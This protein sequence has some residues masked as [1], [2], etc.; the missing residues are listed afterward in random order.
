M[1]SVKLTLFLC[2][3]DGLALRSLDL[4]ISKMHIIFY[5]FLD[6]ISL[7]FRQGSL[8][9]ATILEHQRQTNSVKWKLALNMRLQVQQNF[10]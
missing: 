2:L 10:P 1:I 8:V 4:G 5:K 6:Q 7:D 3:R 9:L